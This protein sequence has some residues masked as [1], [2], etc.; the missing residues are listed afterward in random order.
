MSDQYPTDDKQKDA[1]GGFLSPARHRPDDDSTTTAAQAHGEREH[2]DLPGPPG[3]V[4]TR[5]GVAHEAEEPG[6]PGA[7]T[8]GSQDMTAAEQSGQVAYGATAPG[9]AGEGAVGGE[10]SSG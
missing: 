5:A 7:T 3:Q 9:S 6:S 4:N 8:D 10:S 2:R 1:I